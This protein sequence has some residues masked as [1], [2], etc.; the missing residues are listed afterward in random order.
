MLFHFGEFAATNTGTAA[1]P[2]AD[3]LARLAFRLLGDPLPREASG[4]ERF[5][6]DWID[7]IEIIGRVAVIWKKVPAPLTEQGCASIEAALT[8]AGGG[9]PWGSY[10]ERLITAGLLD[11]AAFAARR[12][13]ELFPGDWA[14]PAR[15]AQVLEQTGDLNGALRAAERSLTLAKATA[16]IEMMRGR[17]AWLKQRGAT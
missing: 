4:M 16:E 17:A 8:R 10:C 11:R 2:M 13:E 6:A 1:T 3:Y 5:F 7:R 15:L 12:G 14:M 9:A